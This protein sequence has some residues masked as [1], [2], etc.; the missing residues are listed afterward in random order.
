MRMIWGDCSGKR[1]RTTPVAKGFAFDLSRNF[2]LRDSKA[3]SNCHSF[4]GYR[5]VHCFF[6]V[7][8][9]ADSFIAY[10]LLSARLIARTSGQKLL[11][12][13]EI[14]HLYHN[15][16]KPY[17]FQLWCFVWCAKRLVLRSG[18]NYLPN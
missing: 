2:S 5:F 9:L 7:F 11:E 1:R 14:S 13:T 15:S 4:A 16:F 3:S 6:F 10:S 12:A 17:F 18:R 8:F